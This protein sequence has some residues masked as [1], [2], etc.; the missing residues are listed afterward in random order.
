VRVALMI[1]GQEDVTWEDWVALAQACERNGFEALFRSDHYISVDDFRDRGSLDAWGTV[2]ALA[3]TTR[4]LRL[5]T[6]V[7]PASFRHPSV[8]AKLVTTADHV[9]GGRVELGLGTGWW[10]SEHTAYGFPFGP[11]GARMDVLAE[12]LEIVRSQW[13]EGAFSFHGAHY[14]LEDLDA[15]PKPVQFPHPPLIVGGAAGPRSAALAARWATE[16]NTVF[17]DVAEARQR[18]DNVMAACEKA[19]R[20]PATMGFSM[21]NGLLI[22]ADEAELRRRGEALAEWRRRPTDLDALRATW[23]AGT[24]G[25]VIMRLREYEE[26]G[27]QRVMLQH[28]LHRDLEVL[29]LIGH[30]VI[31]AVGR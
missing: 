29:D 19:G 9:S 17:P 21:M 12:Q 5:G 6:L 25:E 16:Y 13:A 18:H 3:A 14:T 1:E 27:V 22:G 24:T 28:L 11:M 2:T 26:A 7:S 15:R 23:V 31:P 4:T 30:E 20:D 8:V 10:E